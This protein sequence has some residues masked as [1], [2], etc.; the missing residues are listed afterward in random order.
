M[1]TLFQGVYHHILLPFSC[2]ESKKNQII[3]LN[4]FQTEFEGELKYPQLFS[5]NSTSRVDTS[6]ID[7]MIK[8]KL[9]A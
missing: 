4:Q 7:T 6:K 5:L 1:L 9:I 2:F 8:I 3:F